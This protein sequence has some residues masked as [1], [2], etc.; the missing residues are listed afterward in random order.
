M[1][2]LPETDALHPDVAASPVR[3]VVCTKCDALYRARDV[4]KGTQAVC[5]RCHTVLAAP[6][7]KAGMLI[8]SLAVATL[9]LILAAVFFPFLTLEIQGFRSSAS[10]LD[11]AFSFSDGSLRVLVLLMLAFVLAIPAARAA[12]LT[13]VLAP[14]VFDRAPR[15]LAI[16]AFRLA[17]DLKPWSMAEVFAIGC[18]VSLVKI[19]D[20]AQVSLGQAFW[21]FTALV[22][23][24]V[25]QDKFLCSWSVWNDLTQTRPS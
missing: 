2:F 19:T 1:H 20:L 12:L 24:V 14:L 17:Q 15:P 11:I 21:M 3:Y 23:L 22:A 8:I 7:R 10:L 6:R 13:Y 9:V 16:P 4:E 18:A 5:S 25:T